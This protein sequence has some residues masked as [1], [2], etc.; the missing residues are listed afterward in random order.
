M[1]KVIV[2]PRA[3][4]SLKKCDERYRQRIIDLLLIFRENPVPADYYDTKKVKGHV[5][6][7]RVR[8]GDFRVIYEIKW[9][10][11]QVNVLLVERREVAY[12]GL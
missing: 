1:F 4:K 10:D 9:D 3:K 2:F 6:I 8:I 5:D 7:Y 11:R 12:K